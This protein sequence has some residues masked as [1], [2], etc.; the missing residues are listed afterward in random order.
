MSQPDPYAQPHTD[1]SASQERTLGAVAHGVPL[2]AMVLSAGLLGFVGSLVIY[3][4]YKDR[5]PFVRAH[6]ANSLNVQIITGIVL[7]VSLP[8]ML[9]L[10]GF[11]TYPLAL[12]FAFVLHLLGAVKANS[13]QWWNP[14]L[15]PRFVR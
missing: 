15:T 6:A 11:V 2:V 12:V 13:G 9:V 3:L 8:L 5:G 7:L 4:M 14:P 10:I 1:I